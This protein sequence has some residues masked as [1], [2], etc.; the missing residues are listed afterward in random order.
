MKKKIGDTEY[1]IIPIP[2]HLSPYNARISELLQKK[3]T[4]F[5]D[6]EEISKEIAQHMEKLLNETVT[7]KPNKEHMTAVYNALIDLTNAVLV[8][9]QFFRK[10]KGSNIAKSSS[11]R[12]S[13]SQAPK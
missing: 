3:P 1:N 10:N 5:Q 8:E 6:A 11:A 2:P 9:A 4:S 13:T 7:P 12:I